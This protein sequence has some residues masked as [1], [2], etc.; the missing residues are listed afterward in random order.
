[1]TT[2]ALHKGSAPPET[3]PNKGVLVLVLTA[4]LTGFT[5]VYLSLRPA[6]SAP[7][8]ASPQPT[9]RQI[10]LATL[11]ESQ[12]GLRLAKLR[13]LLGN[14]PNPQLSADIS[15]QVNILGKYETLDWGQ[16][17]DSLYNLQMSRAEKQ[18]AL[19]HYLESWG[20]WT[21]KT[22]IAQIRK[23][24]LTEDTQTD[25]QSLLRTTPLRVSQ[26]KG[27]QQGEFMAGAPV[28]AAPP[29]VI[30][31]PATPEKAPS[32]TVQDVRVKKVKRPHYPSKARRKGIE[33]V[34]TLSLDID[35]RGHVA[36][37]HLVSITATRYQ[38]NFIRAANRAAR[39]SRFYPKTVGGHPVPRSNYLRVF[40]F[41]L[42]E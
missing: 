16:L 7:H 26:F 5:G 30:L 11:A 14:G 10:Y 6:Q 25:A 41:K 12:T 31:Y 8:K 33:S 27:G 17:T 35:A 32:P 29:R 28:G 1:M 15:L 37:T 34:V 19:S 36:R 22:E 20:I 21:R 24:R 23:T 40:T 3:P 38:K 13:N 4:I 39:R 18:Q 2:R 42:D 9:A